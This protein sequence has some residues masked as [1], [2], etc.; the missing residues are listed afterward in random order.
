[1]T[2]CGDCGGNG[3]YVVNQGWDPPEQTQCE[4]CEGFG[5]LLTAEEMVN[6]M[7]LCEI[8]YGSV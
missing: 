1:M 3:W 8:L 4:L 6:Y 5:S 7:N 2:T